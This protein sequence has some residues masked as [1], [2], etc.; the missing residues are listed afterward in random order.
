[1]LP[2]FSYFSSL[3]LTAFRSPSAFSGGSDGEGPDG[4]GLAYGDRLQIRE[5]DGNG[6][7]FL[8]LLLAFT[9]LDDVRDDTGI[10]PKRIAAVGKRNTIWA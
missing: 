2:R 10:E 6:K 3:S 8:F 5:R 1:M 7:Q 4:D 9:C